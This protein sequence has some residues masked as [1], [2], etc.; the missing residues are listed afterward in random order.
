MSEIVEP[1]PHLPEGAL[2]PAWR[3]AVLVNRAN[4]KVTWHP[5]PAYD[6][7]LAAFRQAL[8]ETPEAEAKAEV[9]DAIGFAA[10][11]PHSLVLVRHL[12]RA[13][14]RGPILPRLREGLG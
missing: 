1:R 7:A 9:M 14:T 4:M 6:A 3:E 13:L 8:P 5:D 10:A 11:N 2:R 12:R